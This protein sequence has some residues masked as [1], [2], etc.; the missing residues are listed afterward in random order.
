MFSK[1]STKFFSLFVSFPWLDSSLSV[2]FYLLDFSTWLSDWDDC[3]SCSA[4]LSVTWK[5]LY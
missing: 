4:L 5:L 2:M 3:S 1:N